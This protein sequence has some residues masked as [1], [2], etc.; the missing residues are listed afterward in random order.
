M[1]A[2]A[3]DKK[4]QGSNIQECLSLASFS[5]GVPVEKIKYTILEEKSGFFKKHA[6]ISIDEIEGLNDEENEHIKNTAEDVTNG[7]IEIRLG[8]VIVKNP[9]PGGR[10]ATISMSDNITVTVNGENVSGSTAVYEDSNIGIVFKEVKAKRQM[11]LRTSE[12]KME[13]Y[14][15]IVYNPTIIYKLKDAESK[16]SATLE[17]DVKEEIMPPKFT[18]LEIKNELQNHNITYGILKMNIIKCAKA[19]EVSGVLIATGKKP[20]PEIDDSMEIK[21]NEVNAEDQ[22][23]C[24]NVDSIDYK[25]IG[26]VSGVEK[27]QVLAIVSPGKNGEDGIDITGK[28]I[29]VKAAKKIILSTG[30]GC[31]LSDEFTV[32]ATSEGR[33]S[34]RVNTFFVYKTHEING[35]VEL[36]TGNIKFVGDIV[37][38]GSVLEG[39]KVESGNCILIKNNVAEAEI[40]A[41]G[42][43]VIKGNVIHANV[44]AGKEDVLILEYLSDLNSLKNDVSKLTSSIRQLKEMNLLERNTSDGELIKILLES[45]FKKLPQTATRVAQR[46]LK[47]GMDQDELVYII[48]KK[49]LNLG[50]LNIKNYEELNDVVT[51]IDNKIAILSMNLTLPVNVVLDYCQDSIIKSSGNIIFRGIGQYISQIEASDSVIFQKDKSVARG[52][53][54]K[55]GKE[56][57]CKIVGGLGGV[58]TKLIVENNGHIWAEVAYPNTRFIIGTREYIMDTPSKSVHA[59]IDENRELVVHKLQL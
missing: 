56:I 54:I 12:D 4:F 13:A 19:D 31:Q 23:Q 8:S 18:E 15:S 55:A 5:L 39:M 35:D 26:A 44:A 6:V 25:A 47:Q 3:C 58:A 17:I 51:I 32:V 24:D 20:I 22:Q 46:I 30:E 27:G 42:D 9:K 40:I 7:T 21:F 53:V 11:N 37:I 48:K 33:P 36:K 41:S 59:F 29:K 52:G 1:V 57:K 34:V 38:T 2:K 16:S 28:I 14:I 49:I 10:P 45:K 43:V 50:P